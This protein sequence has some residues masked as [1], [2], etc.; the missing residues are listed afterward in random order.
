MVTPAI[1]LPNGKVLVAAGINSNS[2]G[3]DIL[4]SAELYDPASGT[5]TATGSLA[6]ARDL[7]TATL[8]FDGKV[9]AAAGISDSGFIASAELYDPA[10][11]TWTATGSLATARDTHTATL[12]LDGKVLVAAGTNSSGARKCR[13]LRSGERGVDG[14]R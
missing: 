6:T 13:T 5:W 8:L 10:S 3:A 7:P 11:G 1:L 4:A 12:L 2:Y 9:L 14:D